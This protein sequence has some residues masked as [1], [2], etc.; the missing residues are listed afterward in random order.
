MGKKITHCPPDGD[1][2]LWATGTSAGPFPPA[3]RSKCA[4]SAPL[5][6]VSFL[7][8]TLCNRSTSEHR[9]DVLVVRLYELTK[10]HECRFRNVI[11]RRMGSR[12]SECGTIFTESEGCSTT[13]SQDTTATE[14]T[15]TDS[16]TSSNF[17][18]SLPQDGGSWICIPEVKLWAAVWIRIIALK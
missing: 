2:H 16:T 3:M 17:C 15:A 12:Y 10:N 8:A 9:E 11:Y 4:A 7:K 13:T 14:I 5:A 18:P 6:E 1:L